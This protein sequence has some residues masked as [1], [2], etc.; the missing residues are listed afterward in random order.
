MSLAAAAAFSQAISRASRPAAA[1]SIRAVIEV[2][3][4]CC[5]MKAREKSRSG[6]PD[7][8]RCADRADRC[9]QTAFTRPSLIDPLVMLFECIR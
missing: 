6:R 1:C 4:S 8:R 7:R 3:P 5:A 9:E 2:S